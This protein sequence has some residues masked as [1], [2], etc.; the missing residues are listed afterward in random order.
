MGSAASRLRN[1]GVSL[2]VALAAAAAIVAWR[3]AQCRSLWLLLLAPPS[4]G[5]RI[6]S[7]EGRRGNGQAG[8]AESL[9]GLDAGAL[10]AG[11]QQAEAA[12]EAA[13]EHVLDVLDSFLLSTSTP[14]E[15]RQVIREACARVEEVLQGMGDLVQQL[16]ACGDETALASLSEHLN[17]V[18]SLQVQQEVGAGPCVA[19]VTAALDELVRCGDPVVGAGRALAS[20]GSGARV[21]GLVALASL[22]RVVLEGAVGAEVATGEPVVFCPLRRFCRL[23]GASFCFLSQLGGCASCWVAAGAPRGCVDRRGW[24]CSRCVG[25]TGWGPRSLCWFRT[26]CAP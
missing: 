20:A 11:G 25:A 26:Q 8:G 10:Q 13:L 18:K 7:I 2:A 19:T 5:G 1:S 9:I 4:A 21:R 16:A 24:R 12:L 3:S 22:P 15:Q 17:L 6:G 23:S 14:R